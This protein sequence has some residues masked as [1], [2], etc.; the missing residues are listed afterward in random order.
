MKPKIESIIRFLEGAGRKP[1]SHPGKPFKSSKEN[2]DDDCDLSALLRLLSHVALG[3]ACNIANFI[4]PF[5]F[6][7]RWLTP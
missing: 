3:Q 5:K 1:S 2:A 4:A 6:F 7:K